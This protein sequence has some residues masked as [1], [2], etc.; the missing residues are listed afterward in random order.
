[1]SEPLGVLPEDNSDLALLELN[2]GYLYEC[3]KDVDK[4]AQWYIQSLERFRNLKT[5]RD[6]AQCKTLKIKDLMNLAGV[7][8]HKKEMEQAER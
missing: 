2:I 4:A 6:A 5:I 7:Y 8:S 1:M 3:K